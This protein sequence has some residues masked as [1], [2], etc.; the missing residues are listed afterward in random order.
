MNWNSINAHTWDT[1][2][3]DFA[4]NYLKNPE[5]VNFTNIDKYKF[6]ERIKFYS[7]SNDK[8]YLQLIDENYPP[9]YKGDSTPID[10]PPF[11][12]KVVPPNK[13][14]DILLKFFENETHIAMNE[15]SLYDKVKRSFLLGISRDNIRL[16]L[17]KNPIN[18]K[19][20]QNNKYK[21]EIVKAYRPMFP[22]Q[23]W[24]I[25]TIDFQ[26]IQKYNVVP[27]S[28]PQQYYKHVLVVIDIFTK[29]IYLHPLVGNVDVK[30]KTIT[31]YDEILNFLQRL[32]FFGDIP[33]SISADNF[34][35]KSS[36]KQFCIKHNVQPIFSPP[37]RPQ[38]Q[39]FVEN[40]NKQV[41]SYIFHHFNKYQVYQYFDILDNI[42]FSINN[43][44][45]QSTGRTPMELHRGHTIPLPTQHNKNIISSEKN[46][47]LLNLLN[48]QDLNL[49]HPELDEKDTHNS[50]NYHDFSQRFYNERILNVQDKLHNLAEKRELKYSQHKPSPMKPGYKV[51][52]ANYVTRKDDN[53]RPIQIQLCPF[54]QGKSKIQ[55]FSHIKK[56]PPK[57]SVINPKSQSKL[58][59]TQIK[60]IPISSIEKPLRKS[61]FHIWYEK[62]T[63][64]NP[65]TTSK[66]HTL[67]RIKEVV[68]GDSPTDK[69]YTLTTLDKQF[70]IEQMI[71]EQDGPQWSPYFKKEYLLEATDES[72]NS[73]TQN[74][75][76]RPIYKPTPAFFQQQPTQP[77][78]QPSSTT[79]TQPSTQQKTQ[80]EMIK[81]HSNS[82][83]KYNQQ[84][85]QITN[86][87]FQQISK[88][89]QQFLKK[90]IKFKEHCGFF[91]HYKPL[92]EENPILLY[93]I[94]QGKNRKTETYQGN[95]VIRIV[96]FKY[97]DYLKRRHLSE[98]RDNYIYREDNMPSSSSHVFPLYFPKKTIF[99]TTTKTKIK[100]FLSNNYKGDEILFEYP[101][102]IRY[103][104]NLTIQSL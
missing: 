49:E 12:Y 72:I 59:I 33:K 71:S 52:I 99:Q 85:L 91:H 98:T 73:L 89:P 56:S 30:D 100:D 39:G 18:L 66:T 44:R 96:N 83:F 6:K 16:W 75:P 29:Y 90:I 78:I 103:I 2:T 53:I 88:N 11:T 80:A 20:I 5:N 48:I 77:S 41:K 45:H 54:D 3:Y 7:L 36:F 67:F 23:L 27:N 32:F 15:K 84:G 50:Q 63:G 17:E 35:N 64:N 10:S 97:Q 68:T 101:N 55:L 9:W 95:L 79:L 1:Q 51:H 22:F 25:D 92:E 104:F 19:Q 43:T 8:T 37:Y 21:P 58:H 76:T 82:A 31:M 13:M 24:Q 42:S 94:P 34:F 69:K 38:F 62:K 65:T 81:V 60:P 74:T 46:P 28:K 86:T 26:K 93:A 57:D 40:K 4:I 70:Y 47:N 61:Q 102:V 14:N 87:E